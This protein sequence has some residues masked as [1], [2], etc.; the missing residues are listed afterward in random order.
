MDLRLKHQMLYGGNKQLDQQY[1][2][3]LLRKNDETP[4]VDAPKQPVA[5]L[6]TPVNNS[7]DARWNKHTQAAGQTQ[8]EKIYKML[9]A[10]PH[11]S[12][13]EIA[14]AT[15]IEKNLISDRLQ[16]LI[17]QNRVKI[18]GKKIC[19]ITNMKVTTYEATI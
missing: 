9:R 14:N 2:D 3:K 12:Q 6:F 8:P 7:I 17:K 15:G 10:T 16:R 19:P 1:Y 13:R 18:S 4:T 11:L 5:D